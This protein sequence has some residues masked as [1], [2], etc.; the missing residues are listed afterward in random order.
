M[1]KSIFLNHISALKG[2]KRVF[3]LPKFEKDFA[4]VMYDSVEGCLENS[5]TPLEREALQQESLLR[6]SIKLLY[7]RQDIAK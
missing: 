3:I 1:N 4:S 6:F 2:G 7:A 5:G